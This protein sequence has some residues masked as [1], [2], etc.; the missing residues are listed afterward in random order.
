MAAVNMHA[1]GSMLHVTSRNQSADCS[2]PVHVT[3]TSGRDLAWEK[4]PLSLGCGL[5]SDHECRASD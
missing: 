4:G 5:W 2:A 1:F 3:R